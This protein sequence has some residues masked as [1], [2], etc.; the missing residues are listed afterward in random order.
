MFDVLITGGTVVDGT[1]KPGVASDVGITDGKIAAVGNLSDASAGRSID[2]AGLTVAPGFI[3]THA[4]SDGALLLDPQH[5]NGL[6][7]GITTEILG[8]DGL[9]YA[10]LSH[11][12]YLMYRQYLSGIYGLPP[13]DIATGSVDAF[14]GNYHNRTAINVAFPVPHGAVRIGA[15]G[16]HDQP[17]R[18]DALATARVIVAEGMEQGAI[19]LS[20]GMSYFPN[21]WS[22]TD[23][24]IELCKVV[25]QYGG[26]YITH[27][28]NVHPER[29]F[30]GGG[31]TEA[32]EIGRRSGVNVHFS[33]F[34]TA[35]ENAGHTAELMEEIDRAKAEGIDCTLDLYPYPTG[36]GYPMM[37]L[38]PEANEGGPDAIL[39]RLQ[40]PKSRRSMAAYI[41][42]QHDGIVGNDSSVLTHVP[43]EQNRHLE[44]RSISHAAQ[45]RDVSP[46]E[47][48]CA[49]LLEERLTVGFLQAPPADLAGWEQVSRDAV[50]LMSRPDY[51]VGSDSI[52]AHSRP[53]P[54]AY[55]TFPRLLGRLRRKHPVMSLEQM[56]QRMADNPS[57]RFGLKDRGRIA[58]G[59]AADVV[60]FDAER[61][62]DTATY[63]DPAQYPAGIPFVL[64][65]GVI[66][67]D[68]E[69]CTGS[70]SGQA[71]R[72]S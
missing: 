33:H 2:A 72:R 55:G 42:E 41:D 48:I 51:M 57:R 1:G 36:S 20:T 24:L 31:V 7:Q 4:H 12:D 6:R 13:E 34:R 23:E 30:G 14:L 66:A 64:V 69:R 58:Q 8:Q 54:R 9:S 17:L 28:R 60:V 46:G 5:A 35:V 15:V 26:A 37:F 62:I 18:G 11:E 53:H 10:P 49:L 22:D 70:T 21:S 71:L 40:N 19:G 25:A 50:E 67:V 29:G 52:S 59:Y 61:V 27:L 56:V 43:S 68:A 3:D 65:N 16:F 63:D 38:P 39:E 44:G 32:L 45:K 47:L